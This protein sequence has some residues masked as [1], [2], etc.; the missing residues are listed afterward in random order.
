MHLANTFKGEKIKEKKKETCT[1]SELL[2]FLYMIFFI[3]YGYLYI[4]ISFIFENLKNIKSKTSFL[5]FFSP[6]QGFSLSREANPVTT[7]APLSTLFGLIAGGCHVITFTD[8]FSSTAAAAAATPPGSFSDGELS[9]KISSN[10]P[11]SVNPSS[12]S[13]ASPSALSFSDAAETASF[14]W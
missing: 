10:S 12:S 5:L 11:Q 13:R 8:D 7:F 6:S 14:R 9:P 2:I 4:H 3:L 1:I